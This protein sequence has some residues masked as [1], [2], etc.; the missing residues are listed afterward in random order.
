MIGFGLHDSPAHTVNQQSRTNQLA[1]DNQRRAI[2][3]SAIN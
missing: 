1:R 2:E 3:K